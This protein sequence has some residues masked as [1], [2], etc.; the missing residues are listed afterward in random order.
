MTLSNE[1][2][3]RLTGWLGCLDEFLG[4]YQD[5][6]PY[7]LYNEKWY[8]TV[9][10]FDWLT[11]AEAERAIMDK[12]DGHTIE[13]R[14]SREFADQMVCGID[15]TFY[16]TNPTRIEALINAVLEMLRDGS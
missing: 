5:C 3:I 16:K 6:N 12:L 10:L 13:I 15:Y 1:D 4:D 7:T 8:N 2:A 14:P 9:K 11:T